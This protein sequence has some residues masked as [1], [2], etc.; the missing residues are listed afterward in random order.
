ML[1]HGKPPFLECSSRGDRRFSAF[2]ARVDGRSIE[3]HYQRAKLLDP[4]VG[5]W[6]SAKGRTAL[7]GA[8]VRLLYAT[9]WDRYID[10]NPALWAVLRQATG[11]SDIFG[12]PGSVCQATELW[13]I[14]NQW[15]LL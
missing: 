6:R 1:R 7:N 11:V 12:Q 5:H 3:E 15:D 2:F 8:E 9:L 4:P 14:R 10:E 13:R